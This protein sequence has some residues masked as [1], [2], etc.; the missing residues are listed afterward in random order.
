MSTLFIIYIAHNK[1]LLQNAQVRT[2]QWTRRRRRSLPART[3]ECP[4]AHATNA[5]SHVLSLFLYLCLYVLS[6]HYG[7]LTSNVFPSDV[8]EIVLSFYSCSETICWTWTLSCR[9]GMW[10]QHAPP[11]DAK[12][13]WHKYRTVNTR[14]SIK[15]LNCVVWTLCWMMFCD[16]SKTT[17]MINC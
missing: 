8:P 5:I 17:K 1:S 6:L 13:M 11:R 4:Q 15:S 7:P 12:S 3:A 2:R 14:I 9:R 16:L 10:Q